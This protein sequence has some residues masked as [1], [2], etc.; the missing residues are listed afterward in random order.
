M[1][2]SWK[3]VLVALPCLVAPLGCV[4]SE[5]VRYNNEV[6]GITRELQ[7]AGK[8]FGDRLRSNLGNPAKAKEL[9][10]QI[11]KNGDTI[12]KRGK[13][14]TPPNTTEGKALHK[15]LLS[16]METEDH[17]IRVDFAN[18]ARYAGQN[19]MS[20]ITPIIAAAHQQEQAKV[21]QLKSAQKAFAK[22]NNIPLLN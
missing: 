15:A 4:P 12:I 20:A 3:V 14:L 5:A 1:S 9:H 6:A 22:A 18:V 2:Q 19:K 10:D 21:Q 13:A 17:I 16:Y 11:A 7:A 8:Q